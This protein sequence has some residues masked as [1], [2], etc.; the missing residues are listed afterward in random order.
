[1]TPEPRQP[2]AHTVL[3]VEDDAGT[4]DAM[5]VL[6]TTH[7]YG[8]VCARGADAAL[9]LVRAEPHPCVIL[10]DLMMSGLSGDE[11][12]RAQ[13]ADRAVRDIPVILISGAHDLASR[14]QALNAAAYL[15]K[16]LEVD[17]LLGLIARHCVAESAIA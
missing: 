11:F 5:E 15:G 2:H 7:G 10:L 1:M 8:V 3:I 13:L 12:R 6:L 14:A 4:R 17:T 9:T 16:P